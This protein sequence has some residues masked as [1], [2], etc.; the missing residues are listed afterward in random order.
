MWRA[1]SK[2][3]QLTQGKL[4]DDKTG[5]QTDLRR[6]I[7]VP[8]NFPEMEAE[9]QGHCRYWIVC[10]KMI[11]RFIGK[12]VVLVHPDDVQM[13]VERR[14]MTFD[15]KQNDFKDCTMPEEHHA[16]EMSSYIDRNY[17][18]LAK[19]HPE[20]L[21][22]KR[23]AAML[24]VAKWLLD[25]ALHGQEAVD[26][27]PDFAIPTNFEDNFVPALCAQHEKELTKPAAAMA[28]A[29]ANDLE[30]QI[31]SYRSELDSLKR[32]VDESER[33]I[34]MREQSLD[35]SDGAAVDSL[36]VQ[37]RAHNAKLRTLRETQDKRNQLV[38]LH[39][40]CVKDHNALGG[41]Q[42][43]IITVTGGVDLHADVQEKPVLGIG[44]GE[45]MQPFQEIAS[46]V[47]NHEEPLINPSGNNATSLV[48]EI[49]SQKDVVL[50]VLRVALGEAIPR[51]QVRK[52]ILHSLKQK[53]DLNNLV[54]ELLQPME[55]ER[56]R[57]R[58][59]MEGTLLDVKRCNFMVEKTNVKLIDLKN[60]RLNG[61]VAQIKSAQSA[62]ALRYIVRLQSG[63]EVAVQPKN[64][65]L[66]T[67]TW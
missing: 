61:Q 5:L 39:R 21:H 62:P 65:L 18:A 28:L 29:K 6:G 23:M 44:E 14:N 45:I 10:R 4:Y 56:D 53:S 17:D 32:Q 34:D 59:R 35:R 47:C 8:S 38:D 57:Y 67:G 2:L 48:D 12:H 37:V 25:G 42:R 66:P 51:K 60:A 19:F 54:G 13:G 11:L 43:S 58:I 31:D 33:M 40:Q 27:T 16:T 9:R 50:N 3:K 1:D 26:M 63:D 41:I 15:S 55:K 24:A 49:R 20:L 46:K 64:V 22:C 36:N 30:W 7:N 52:V